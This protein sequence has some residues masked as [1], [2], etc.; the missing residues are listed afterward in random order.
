ML[1]RLTKLL[2]VVVVTAFGAGCVMFVPAETTD[3]WQS[4][5]DDVTNDHVRVRNVKTPDLD[6][7]GI[8]NGSDR[9]PFSSANAAVNEQGCEHDVDVDGVPD[10]VDSCLY[11]KPGVPVDGRGCALKGL[12]T[13]VSDSDGDGVLDAND[14]CANTLPGQQ[15]DANGCAVKKLIT[16]PTVMFAFG[17]A[18]LKPEGRSV[19]KVFAER[20]I[21]RPTMRLRVNGHTDS[22]DS[23]DVNLALS[24][25]RALAVKNYLVSQGVEPNR[26]SAEGFGETKP[27]ASNATQAGRLKNRRVELEILSE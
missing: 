4:S 27:V 14:K 6:N 12:A 8:P 5:G 19:L 16:L 3:S 23:A 15:V 7:D 11:T 25:A 20:I 13:V 17:K 9:C 24:Y 21:K 10:Y 18:D 22:I 2:L 1:L 26:L